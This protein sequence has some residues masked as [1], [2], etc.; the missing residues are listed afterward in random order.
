VI[1]GHTLSPEFA[2]ASIDAFSQQI[3]Y[4]G[5]VAEPLATIVPTG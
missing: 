1:K 5:A 3:D 2:K 4:P